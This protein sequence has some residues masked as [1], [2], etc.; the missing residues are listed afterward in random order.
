MVPDDTADIVMYG[1][2]WC[3]DCTR[4]KRL[5]DRHRVPYRWV[6]IEEEP[7]AAARVMELNGGRRIVPTIVFPDGSLLAE[8][9]DAQLARKLGLT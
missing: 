1:A 3:P 8:P 7:D 2:T 9:S 4:S 6:N 5:L